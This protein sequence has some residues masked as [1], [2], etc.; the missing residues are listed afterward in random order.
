MNLFEVVI[1]DRA[2]ARFDDLCAAS[3]LESTRAATQLEE[4]VQ[5]LCR[6]PLEHVHTSMR[7]DGTIIGHRILGR[8]VPI[9][10]EWTLDDDLLVRIDTLEHVRLQPPHTLQPS[11]RRL[12]DLRDRVHLRCLTDDDLQRYAAQCTDEMT[13]D[14]RPTR[15]RE[16]RV[17][18]LVSRELARRGLS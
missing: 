7:R 3:R 15:S 8:R 18:H 14:D 1:V 5:Q 17:L 10:A 4:L 16:Q 6:N 2:A 12:T 9:Y 11:A 13:R